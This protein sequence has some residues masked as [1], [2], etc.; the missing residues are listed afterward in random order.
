MCCGSSRANLEAFCPKKGFCLLSGYFEQ[1]KLCKP[2]CSFENS[3]NRYDMTRI[4]GDVSKSTLRLQSR[5]PCRIILLKIVETDAALG[6]FRG[7]E[8][9]YICT[10]SSGVKCF[11]DQLRR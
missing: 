6:V 10:V 9:V 8:L 1:L 7:N 5:K 3:H 4:Y 11:E 2:I